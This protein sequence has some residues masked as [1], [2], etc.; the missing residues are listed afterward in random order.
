MQLA[1][2]LSR[3]QSFV[4]K[5]ERGERRIDVIEFLELAHAIGI[6]ANAFLRV[7]NDE[8]GS[9]EGSSR[10]ENRPRGKRGK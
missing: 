4:S 6:D 9:P 2:R 5:I 7:L 1:K 3:P 8:D 10:H